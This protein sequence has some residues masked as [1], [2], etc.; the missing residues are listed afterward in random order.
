MS[1]STEIMAAMARIESFQ[2]TTLTLHA[3]LQTT[4]T[5]QTKASEAAAVAAVNVQGTAMDQ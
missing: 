5:M 3:D 1:T 4:V 2:R